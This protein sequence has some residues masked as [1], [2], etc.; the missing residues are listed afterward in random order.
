LA[1]GV[2]ALA[3]GPVSCNMVVGGVP[4][5]L[6]LVVLLILFQILASVALPLTI[7]CYF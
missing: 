1:T 5:V 7:V 2:G 3:R 4:R 6:M